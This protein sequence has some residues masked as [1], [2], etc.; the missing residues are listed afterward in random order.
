MIF[1]DEFEQQEAQQYIQGTPVELSK[2]PGKIYIVAEYD[3]MMVPP[4]W[5]VNDP[6]PRYPHELKLMVSLFCPLPLRI[7]QAA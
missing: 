7:H 4:V 5:L 1:D 2:E 6:R 3:P